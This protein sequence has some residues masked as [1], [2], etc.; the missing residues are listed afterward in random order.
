MAE[1]TVQ[2]RGIRKQFPS[3]LAND[4]VD[5]T[6][7]RGEIHALLGENGA[8]KSTLM[9]ILTGVLQPDAGEICINGKP[10]M[11]R[12]PKD[13]LQHGIG[14]IYQHFKL[15]KPFSVAEN[16]VLSDDHVKVIN[17]KRLEARVKA[18]SERYCIEIDPGALTWQLSIGE[19]QRVEILKVL[20]RNANILILDEPT[21]VLT[22]QEVQELFLTL[23]KMTDSGC[24]VIFI[25]HKMNEV[26][27]YADRIT[28]L[29]DGCLVRTL[30]KAETDEKELAKL[31]VG[32][33]ISMGRR[34]TTDTTTDRELLRVENLTV[35]NDKKLEA[36]RKLSFSL[37][38]GEILGIAGVSGNGQK[39]LMEALSG[40]RA[41]AGGP[42]PFK[43]KNITKTTVRQRISDGLSFIP[44]DR[45][46]FALVRELSVAENASIKSYR[47]PEFSKGGIVDYKKL[48]KQAEEF[49][50]KFEIKVG[51][52]KSRVQS[53]SGGNAQK[54][55][56]ARE[57]SLGNKLLVASQPTRG[58]DIGAI[59]L[60]RNTLEKAKKAGAGVLLVSAELEGI[61]SL[62]DRIVVIHEGKITGEMRA[63]EANENNLGL[64]MMG[65]T[66]TGK[67]GE[68][69]V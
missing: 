8:G 22:A 34:N 49:I 10:V 33:E 64:L 41:A 14:M 6:A 5:F 45:Y 17:K 13:A 26:M 4:N 36:V 31:M 48:N 21:A 52:T 53:M 68:A 40:L 39:E 56:V 19:Q 58:V 30:T 11:I 54:V 28:V 29:R 43:E 15:V 38:A 69:A 20:Y 62:S 16:I 61:I 32:R 27:D 55:V 1:A 51:W 63:D 7:Y 46:G 65:G 3:C 2:M 44:E 67:D 37:Y 59:E 50:D 42:I 12:T 60:I 35:L 66:D 9:S 25:T 23:R 18:L 24:T 57:V 47:L